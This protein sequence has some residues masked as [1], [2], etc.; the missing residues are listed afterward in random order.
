[1]DVKEKV[2]KEFIQQFVKKDCKDILVDDIAFNIGMSKRTI[3]ENFHS[4]SEIIRQTLKHYLKLEHEQILTLLSE[5]DNPLKKILIT[6]FFF[7]DSASKI[8]LNRLH[9]LKRQYPE[10]AEELTNDQHVFVNDVVLR[11]YLQAQEEG[12]LFKDIEPEFIIVLLLGGERDP[13]EKTVN[14]FGKEFDSIKLFGAHFFTIIR[15][16]STLKGVEICD[17][18]Y[19]EWQNL[20]NIKVI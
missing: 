19:K 10:I 4:K 6:S 3:Y 20:I 13:R 15:G 2:M 9:N 17:K 14:F 12:F 1:M 16:V 18:F 8:S 7:I 5:E 11:F